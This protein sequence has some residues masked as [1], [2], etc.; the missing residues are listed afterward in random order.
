VDLA[1][2]SDFVL[3][4]EAGAPVSTATWLRE[5]KGF[6][7]CLAVPPPF[8]ENAAQGHDEPVL[9]VP[10]FLSPDL[11]TAVLR[12]F[13]RRQG[14]VPEP[15]GCGINFG[16]TPNALANLRACIRASAERHGRKVSVVGISLGGTLAR[17]AA[18][19]D[20]DCI[21][22]LI[23]VAS[24]VNLPVITPLAPLARLASLFWDANMKG[25]A[26][27][28]AEPPP[29]PLIAIF[30]PNDGILDWHACLPRP[31]R[32]TEI[33]ALS[34]DHM[35]MASNPEV[36]RVIAARLAVRQNNVG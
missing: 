10:A 23:T 21:E 4:P 7:K 26:A 15:W 24:P 12:R 31:S 25:A 29:I 1:A 30:S 27:R 22:Q 17:E 14:F 16:P 34:G 33:V 18:K 19:R 35:T 9:L 5:L 6:A 28:V 20:P 2:S 8:P 3:W 32:Q 36:L 13:L 11:S